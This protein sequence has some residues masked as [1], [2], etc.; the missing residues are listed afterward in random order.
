MP[1]ET[2]TFLT[3]DQ[4]P[5]FTNTECEDDKCMSNT[6]STHHQLFVTEGST[7]IAQNK[8]LVTYSRF[9]ET[10]VAKFSGSD[11]ATP[12]GTP[13]VRYVRPKQFTSRGGAVLCEASPVPYYFS[14][15]DDVMN[16][17]VSHKSGCTCSN[18]TLVFT[19]LYLEC[20]YGILHHSTHHHS[21]KINM[22]LAK[23]RTIQRLLAT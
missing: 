8:P 1:S 5:R 20:I 15:S 19:L 12:R 6:M 23:L 7:A 22:E 17:V 4:L 2:P 13:C 9:S 18:F 11:P 3:P 10:S 14:L 21:M 16:D